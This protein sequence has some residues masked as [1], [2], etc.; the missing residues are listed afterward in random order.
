MTTND[1]PDRCPIYDY[2]LSEDPQFSSH[3]CVNPGH[4]Q[5]TGRLEFSDYY[6]MAKMLTGVNVEPS[7]RSGGQDG[8]ENAASQAQN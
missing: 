1:K 8:I 7:Q 6:L 4:W 3:R 5:A 2:Y